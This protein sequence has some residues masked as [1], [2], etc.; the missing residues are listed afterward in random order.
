VLSVFCVAPAVTT[1]WIFTVGKSKNSGSND[2]LCVSRG[3]LG[4]N[5]PVTASMWRRTWGTTLALAHQDLL[6][7]TDRRTPYLHT[8]HLRVNP[9]LRA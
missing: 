9:A 6:G 1:F 5:L 4:R 2:L 3:E 8:F 7:G